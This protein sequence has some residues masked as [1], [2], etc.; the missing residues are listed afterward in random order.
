[1]AKVSASPIPE[2]KLLDFYEALKYVNVGKRITRKE[3]NNP[4]IYGF[5]QNSLVK[6]YQ[7]GKIDN[8]I[9]S[10]GDLTAEDWQVI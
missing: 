1:M 8:W 7:T 4:E 3:W 9:V 10:V 5:L 6:I 2:P